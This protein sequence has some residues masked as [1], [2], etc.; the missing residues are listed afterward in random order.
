[1]KSHTNGFQKTNRK[2]MV[3]SKI[4]DFAFINKI[5]ID[6]KFWLILNELQKCQYN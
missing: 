1:M 2:K 5:E 3:I 4:N 6:G